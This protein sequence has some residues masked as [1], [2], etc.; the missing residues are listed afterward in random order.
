[1]SALGLSSRVVMTM[2]EAQATLAAEF[3]FTD[4]VLRDP[5]PTYRRFLEDDR[6]LH[7]VPYLGGGWAVLRATRKLSAQIL[8]FLFG[9]KPPTKPASLAGLAGAGRSSPS[10]DEKFYVVRR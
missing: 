3:L 5:Y 2:S 1:M 8:N 10:S 6:I 4:E 9:D 7:P